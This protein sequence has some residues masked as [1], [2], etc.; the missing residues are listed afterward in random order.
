MSQADLIALP[1]S[2]LET[3]RER[4]LWEVQ[5]EKNSQGCERS[6]QADIGNSSA[7]ATARSLSQP[8]VHRRVRACRALV[9]E[10]L[11]SPGGKTLKEK[12]W[13]KKKKNQ[14]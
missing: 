7:G 8:E 13:V 3:Q 10:G 12:L 4:M 2:N 1:D 14:P 6:G 5:S 11:F 9:R